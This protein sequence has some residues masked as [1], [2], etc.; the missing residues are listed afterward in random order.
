[1]KTISL[2]SR[3]SDETVNT[4]SAFCP[5][6]VFIL[7]AA[8]LMQGCGRSNQ[9]QI[10]K[11][12][13]VSEETPS[14]HPNTPPAVAAST[15]TIV[16]NP[17]PVPAGSGSGIT[18]ISW[19]TGDGTVGDVYLFIDGEEK[20]FGRHWKDSKQVDWIIAGLT[21]EFRLYDSPEKTKLLA[22]VKVTREKE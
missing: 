21:Y 22:S 9:P 3:N 11:Q 12:E 16:A 18:T 20:L 2:R 10:N 13:T 8:L 14:D 19:N 1:M 15:A 7:F 6:L 4:Q 5:L 17:N